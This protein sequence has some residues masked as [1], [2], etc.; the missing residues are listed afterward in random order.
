VITVSD[1]GIGFDRDMQRR[2]FVL[3]SQ[4]KAA[5]GRAAGGMGIGLALVREFVER[6]GGTVTGES[7]GPGKGS[8]FTVRIPCLEAGA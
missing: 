1:N 2:L 4:D 8:R 7:G 5:M 3:F 6:H